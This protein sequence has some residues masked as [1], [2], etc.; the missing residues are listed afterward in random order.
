MKLRCISLGLLDVGSF[1]G[2]SSG[3][4][5]VFGVLTAALRRHSNRLAPDAVTI[6]GKELP[7]VNKPKDPAPG[8]V[9][10]RIT[11]KVYQLKESADDQM[12]R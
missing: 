12:R 8:A 3:C 5:S 2:G 7:G 10:P 1:L 4:D 9:T 6:V 11:G